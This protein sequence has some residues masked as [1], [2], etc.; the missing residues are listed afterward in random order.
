LNELFSTWAPSSIPTTTIP[1]TTINPSHYSSIVSHVALITSAAATETNSVSLYF[2]AQDMRSAMAALTIISGQKYL[3][4]ATETQQL[5][6]VTSQLVNATLNLL[7]IDNE[8]NL[9]GMNPNRIANILFTVLFGIIFL[10]H[11]GIGIFTKQTYFTACF[12][13]G[14]SLEFAGYLSRILA[15]NHETDENLFLCQI[16]T[17]TMAPAFIMAGIYFL[18]AQVI[19]IY[20][21]N[22]SILP[23]LWFSY[24]FVFCDAMSLLV[25]AIGGGMAS[26]ALHRR[27][28]LGPGTHVMLGGICFQVLSMSLFLILLF[29]FYIRSYFKVNRTVRFGCKNFFSLLLHNKDGQILRSQLEPHYNPKYSTIRTRHLFNH[30]PLVLLV[31]TIF[32]Y[33]RC[34]YRVAELSE[35]WNGYLIRREAF[36]MTL[37]ALLICLTSALFLVFHPGFMFGKDIEIS[38]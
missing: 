36:P 23:P 25:Q 17:L 29:D 22:C 14:T 34:A 8:N 9:Y 26:V 2:L 4:T 37:D 15:H 10:A 19:V 30:I 11:T 7:D 32:V 27:A 13:C 28:A 35:G 6:M 12:F 5:P 38:V 24:V 1:L 16:V 3:A 31:A 21:R 33:I 18:L 20:G